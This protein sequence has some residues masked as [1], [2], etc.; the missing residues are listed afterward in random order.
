MFSRRIGK[1][2]VLQIIKTGEVIISYPDDTPFPS[3]LVLGF[4]GDRPIHVVIATVELTGR[5]VVV[6]AYEPDESIWEKDFRRR[7]P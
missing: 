3:S 2:D 1:E 5:C 7:K 6:T 4:V